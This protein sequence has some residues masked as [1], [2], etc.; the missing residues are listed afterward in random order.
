M[1]LPVLI[2]VV[3]AFLGLGLFLVIR[4]SKGKKD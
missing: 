3:L 1:L 4:Q 2:V